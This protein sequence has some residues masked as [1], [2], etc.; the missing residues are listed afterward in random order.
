M[1]ALIAFAAVPALAS[2]G[3]DFD[4]VRRAAVALTVLLSGWIV[5]PALGAFPVPLVG[6]GLSPI[7]GVW[8][9]VGLLASLRPA[10]GSARL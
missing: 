6:V 2:R 4:G 1:L 10:S 8:L 3:R 9:G 5:A 7:L